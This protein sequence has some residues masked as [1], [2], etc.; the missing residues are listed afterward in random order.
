MAHRDH[1]FVK[2]HM[3]FDIKM[4]NF[5][6]KARMVVGGHTTNAPSSVTYAS[7]FLRETVCI[8]LTLASLNDLEVKCGDF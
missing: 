1:Q 8:D 4:E 6:R 5:W 2:C 3:I 7:V